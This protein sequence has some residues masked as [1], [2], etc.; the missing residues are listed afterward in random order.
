MVGSIEPFIKGLYNA[1]PKCKKC[2]EVRQYWDDELCVN[3]RTQES[4]KKMFGGYPQPLFTKEQI[5]EI[6]REIE[7]DE[8]KIPIVCLPPITK[9]DIIWAVRH[10]NRKR[11][12]PNV[13]ELKHELTAEEEETLIKLIDYHKETLKLLAE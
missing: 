7:S 9:E 1:A 10:P 2:G 5:K 6:R 13:I 8:Y 12:V 3:C 4:T 11:K